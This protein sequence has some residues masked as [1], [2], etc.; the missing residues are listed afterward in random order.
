[1]NKKGQFSIIAALLVAVILITTVI[2]TY[3]TIR[4]S[5]VQ[6][7]PPILNAID[8]T[9]LAIKQILG[10]TVGYY[11]S[12]LQITGNVSYA[13]I[14][15][16]G[17]L[18]SGLQNIANM[19]PEWGTSINLNSSAL[20]AYWFSSTSYSS[21]NL[22]VNYN[23]PGL[24]ILGVTYQAS[25][26]LGVQTINTTTGQA[27]LNITQDQNQPLVTLGTQ[28]FNFYNYS[29]TSS[30]W[31]LVNPST[32]PTAYANGTY[33]VNV[34]PGINPHS[35]VIQVEDQRGII[36][37]ASSFNSYTSTLTWN[38]TSVQ[39]GSPIFYY[40]N[41]CNSNFDSDT[42][43]HSNFTAQQSSTDN[44]Y[45]NLIENW[46]S[47][48]PSNAY[49]PSG[50]TLLNST[51]ISGSYANLQA[52]DSQYMTF[53]SNQSKSS[54]QALYAHSETTNINGAQYYLQQQVPADKTGTN[55]SASMSTIGRQ[56]LG[57]FVYPL[58][59]VSSIPASA[60]TMYYRAWKDADQT[61]GFDNASSM[62]LSTANTSMS[63]SHTTGSGSNRLLIVAIGVYS[64][65][66]TPTTVTS[67][68]YGGTS[69]AQQ[70]TARY[71]TNPQVR[72]YTFI[73]TNPAS[74][75][76]IVK[77]NFA[78]S[79]VAEAGAVTYYGVDQTTPIQTNNTNTGSSTSETASVTVS[80]TGRWVFGYLASY[81][82]SSSYTITDGS[83]Q[84]LR[85]NQT[86]A[87]PYK[88]K[89]EDKSNV[90]SGSVSLSWNTSSTV[91]WAV[92]VLC[93][94]PATPAVG[95]VDVD[96]S[97]RESN[98]TTRAMIS[99]TAAASGSISA[100]ATTLSGNYSWSNYAVQNQTDY[101]E[102]DYYIDVST[103][104]Q[105]TYAYLSIDNNSLPLTDQTRA[106]NIML[107]SQYTVGIEFSG[108]SDTQSWTQLAW[109]IDSCFTMPNVTA[110]FWL[111]NYTAGAY[112]TSGNGYINQT[113]GT[114]NVT[115]TQTI[116][117]NPTQ[118][119]DVNGNWKLKVQGVA[120][121]QFN[122]SVDL[123]KYQ[124][125]LFNYELDL[126]E[127]WVNLN[128]AN[129]YTQLCIKTGTLGQEP[130]KV[131]VWN[132]SAHT[133]I[134]VLN[135]LNASSWNNVTV[136]GYLQSSNF[137]IRFKDTN[138]T[139]DSVQDTWQIDAALLTVWPTV[140][141]YS[142]SRQGTIVV[143]L[144]QNGTMRWLGQ[145]LA[146]ANSNSTLPFPP[147]PVKAIH[148]NETINGVNGEVPF[149][150]EDWS[151][152]YHVPLGLT[153]N[154]SIFSGRTMLVFLATPNASKVT[155]WWNGSDMATQ[156]PYAYMNRYF[157]DSP[158]S[159]TISN[160]LTKLQIQGNFVVN[161]TVGGSSSTANFMRINSNVS[162]YGSLPSY[163]ITNG[164]VRD[165]VHQE[166]EW[167]NQTNWSQGGVIN[168]SDI[169]A[170]IVLTLPANATYY[171][172]QLSLMFVQSQ[173]NRTISDLCPVWLTS[174]TGQVIQTENGTTN[175]LPNVSNAS[176]L[177]YN[178]SVS[179]WAHHW[180]QSIS[181]TNGTGIMFTDNANQ[182]LYLFDSIKG[183]QTGALGANST[184][185][186][187]QLLPV[188][189]TTVSFSQ[190]L[191]PRMQDIVWYGA[192]A[193]FNATTT[194]IYNNADQTGLWILVEYPP[195]VAVTGE[196]NQLS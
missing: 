103:A 4:S 91:S 111:Y 123:I 175:G 142:L 69:L 193:T 57:T 75:T 62:T 131:D 90:S 46:T 144:L 154:M 48:F 129:N 20:Q 65:S 184:A 133:W 153:S 78:A 143:E 77:V 106:A 116:T 169:Y 166:A 137:T 160:G 152:A 81:R 126:E 165:I 21:G 173:Q 187:I 92:S 40:V 89:A 114:A 159:G 102:I 149:Q 174:L 18:Q 88:G 84:N 14:L 121:Q 13:Q 167:S 16:T 104:C 172:Y 68:T 107:P 141:L 26:L 1:M 28:N 157:S 43:T 186:T 79:T 151:S 145:N 100:T 87:Q 82:T 155:I 156:T 24:G 60:W 161:S 32:E 39:A 35:Y 180:S 97:I 10:F 178:Y 122:W 139:S 70:T 15:A 11:G 58:T 185:Q 38:S 95:K 94:N 194:P 140:D 19:H 50:Y 54:P 176:G 72:E 5:P 12:V 158:S 195:A 162:G 23:L 64:S 119:R 2:V 63:W 66:S 96:V 188:N 80:G 73:L 36:V 196:N 33:Y 17:Y 120:S 8:E 52:D 25:C 170:D 105:G 83:S 7:Q 135:S 51:Y 53:Q 55:L 49:Y 117:V 132:D 31:Q 9:N 86:T 136:T 108:T 124:V 34:P 171:T 128:Y 148:V 182:N 98:N 183:V 22:T 3:S 163:V 125:F 67:V 44:A 168:C 190:T 146:V 113:I 138:E 164:V 42:G 93:I 115:L 134:T 85:W 179:A 45:D 76:N 41:N 30:T 6:N 110:T 74:G 56:L 112:P 118:F 191:D 61:I 127:Q 147:V 181:G 109:T 177:F 29:N 71:S 189:R 150:I 59:N 101:L 27:C 37:V 99:Q 192:I 47:I 130:L